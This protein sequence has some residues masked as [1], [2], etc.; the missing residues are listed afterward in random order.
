M[1]EKDTA[2]AT[3]Q[4]ARM[5]SRMQAAYRV[6]AGQGERTI[7]EKFADS[8]RPTWDN[9]KKANEDK[10]DM[11]GM[12]QRKMEDYRKQLDAEREKMLARGTN[13]KSS[14][15]KKK[16]KKYNSS[17]SDSSDSEDSR[18]RR[19]EKKKRK[20]KKKK[21]SGEGTDSSGD[22]SV[23]SSKKRTKKKKKKRKK[24]HKA[25]SDS[26]G[27]HYRLSKFFEG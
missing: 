27:S 20:R 13:H 12:D 26:E 18:K 19:K 6:M 11:E 10:L 5:N 4:A 22:N 2:Q 7:A 23:D 25:D 3:E 14:K 8:N 9:Y 21:D 15:K 17:D 24:K 16:R 1:S